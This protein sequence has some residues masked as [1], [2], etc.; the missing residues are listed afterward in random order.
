MSMESAVMERERENAVMS[1]EV[2]VRREWYLRS[3]Q[4]N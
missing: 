3:S 2:I 4:M 1:D